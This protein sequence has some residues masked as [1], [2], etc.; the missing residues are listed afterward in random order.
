MS[1]ESIEDRLGEAAA[2]AAGAV[3]PE[4]IQRLRRDAPSMIAAE[5][6]MQRGF[7][8]RLAT[9]WQEP[10]ELCQMVLTSAR[11]MVADFDQE[12]REEAVQKQDFIF[13]FEVLHRLAIRACRVAEEVLCLLRGG[14]AGGAHARWRT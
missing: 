10:F 6:E 1:E 14:F 4:I 13:V 9:R 7:E 11:E 2:R 8:E 5:R 3:V 12:N